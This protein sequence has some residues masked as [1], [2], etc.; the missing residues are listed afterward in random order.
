[1]SLPRY[2]PMLATA[3]SQPFS[4]DD[5]VFEEKVDGFRTLLYWD[6]SRVE[7]RSRSGRDV[8]HLYPELT[9]FSAGRPCVVDGEAVVRDTDGVPRFELMQHRTGV[10][11]LGSTLAE[12]PVEFVAFD[13]LFDGED[14]TGKGLEE[15]RSH[16]D[17]VAD[18]LTVSNIVEEDGEGLWRRVEELGLEGMMAKR[19]GSA[20][21]PGRRVE[22]WRKI[23]RTLSIRTVVGG[24]TVGDG[25]RAETF[26]SLQ[27]GLWRGDALQ[28]VGSVGTG[29]SDSVL[30]A[31]RAALD[32]QVTEVSPFHPEADLPKGVRWV[33]PTLVAMVGIKEWTRHNRMR[34]P[35]FLGF[36]D[37]EPTT[38]TW[39]SERGTKL[40]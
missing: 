35:R 20:Y 37:D 16:L 19:K 6:G 9:A 11:S 21:V 28:W 17:P 31:I 1:M 14:I 32:Q 27:V 36:T 23:A 39:E 4:D 5:W 15:R 26:G 29:F 18:I 40:A 8:T 3:W 13:V 10:P 25:G 33:E 22:T 24:F 38:V 12:Y 34:A 30:V 7:L 2:Q